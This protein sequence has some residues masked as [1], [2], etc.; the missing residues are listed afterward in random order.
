MLKINGA[1]FINKTLL[2]EDTVTDMNNP[3]C[4]NCNECCSILSMLLEKEYKD[5]K[6]YLKKDKEGQRVYKEAVARIEKAKE[7][8]TLSLMCPFSN[9]KKRC[10]IYKVR[11]S[12]CREFHCTK[13]LAEDYDKSKYED[14]HQYTIL[15][16][17]KR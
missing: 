17:F 2:E 11:P 15:D 1:D 10:S 13:E 5:L 14:E 8:N 12:I 9:S 4:N 7:K 3:N 16:L 6:K